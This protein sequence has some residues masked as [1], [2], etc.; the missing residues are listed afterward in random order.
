MDAGEN[1]GRFQNVA[2]SPDGFVAV[3]TDVHERFNE[4]GGRNLIYTY[5]PPH[6][7][8]N[9]LSWIISLKNEYYQILILYDIVRADIKTP[10]LGQQNNYTKV[11]S[12]GQLWVQFCVN[13]R[14][15]V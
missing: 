8:S 12:V 2:R 7:I 11:I 4:N 13:D 10:F 1:I 14:I 9:N 6:I 5:T 15:H 3:N